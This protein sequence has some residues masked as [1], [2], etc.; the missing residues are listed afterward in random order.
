MPTLQSALE[1]LV[2]KLHLQAPPRRVHH[3][4][5][6]SGATCPTIRPWV[7]PLKRPSVTNATENA[8]PAA[9]QRPGHIQHSRMPG[10]AGRALGAHHHHHLARLH[11]AVQDG[12]E[13]EADAPVS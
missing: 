8:Q 11:L 2:R 7:A 3:D 10:P 9:D 1:L 5:V 12:L 4:H 6:A 13:G